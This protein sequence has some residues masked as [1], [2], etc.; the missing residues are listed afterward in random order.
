MNMEEARKVVFLIN[1]SNMAEYPITT[2]EYVKLTLPEFK[3]ELNDDM[4]LVVK[5]TNTDD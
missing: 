4:D 1:N 2:L 3:W 5:E